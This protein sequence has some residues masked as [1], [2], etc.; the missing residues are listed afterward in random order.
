MRAYLITQ[1]RS[2][3]KKPDIITAY[4]SDFTDQFGIMTYEFENV[5]IT[6]TI[7]S[8]ALSGIVFSVK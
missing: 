8:D 6:V 2:D 5:S 1:L 7:D 4:G 3:Q